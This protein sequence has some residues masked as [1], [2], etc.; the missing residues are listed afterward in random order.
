[1]D[2]SKI[3][4]QYLMTTRIPVLE[5]KFEGGRFQYRWTNVLPGFAM[6]VRVAVGEG[7][8]SLIRPTE[9]WRS[10]PKPVGA[11][12]SLVVDPNFYVQ[13]KRASDAP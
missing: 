5:Y 1:M 13:V 4:Q 7:A 8:F 9:A 11:S 6:P 2:F 12:D 10:L 3:F